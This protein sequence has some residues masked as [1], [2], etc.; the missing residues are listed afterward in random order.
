MGIRNILREKKSAYLEDLFEEY[1]KPFVVVT[2]MSVLEMVKE[3]DVIIKQ[4]KNFDKI[5]IELRS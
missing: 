5:L 1:N 4:D 2:F 3:R